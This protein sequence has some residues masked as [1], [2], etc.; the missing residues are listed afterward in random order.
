MI[1]DHRLRYY[2]NPRGQ[3]VHYVGAVEKFDIYLSSNRIN[4]VVRWSDHEKATFPVAFG[5]PSERSIRDR[6]RCHLPDTQD[7]VPMRIAMMIE[8]FS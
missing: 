4:Y 1:S 3:R 5:K 2:T 7:D 6:L 8:L